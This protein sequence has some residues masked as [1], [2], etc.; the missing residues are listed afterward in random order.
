MR[1]S[2]HTALLGLLLAGLAGCDVAEQS[3]QKLAEQA[4]QA[5]REAARETVDETL[6]ELN[7]QVDEVQQSPQEWLGKPA[8]QQDAQPAEAPR[9]DSAEHP[10][11]LPIES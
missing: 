5:V 2:V 1:K 6:K 10:G 3:A 4:E 9:I 7:K 11:E 8:E